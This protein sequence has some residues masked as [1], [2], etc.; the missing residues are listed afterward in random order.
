MLSTIRTIA[1]ATNINIRLMRRCR[2]R[3]MRSTCATVGDQS[4]DPRSAL[5]MIFMRFCLNIL[6]LDTIVICGEL[7]RVLGLARHN[8]P[9]H[10]QDQP[11]D[12]YAGHQKIKRFGKIAWIVRYFVA[13]LLIIYQ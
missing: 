7:A 10:C 5:R 13:F 11:A 8:G 9:G 12:H 2:R 3:F 4:S 6:P 1:S